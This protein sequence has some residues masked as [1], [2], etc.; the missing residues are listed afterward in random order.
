[1]AG[2]PSLERAGSVHAARLLLMLLLGV[3]LQNTGATRKKDMRTVSSVSLCGR[4]V[5]LGQEGISEGSEQA[6][7]SGGHSSLHA[8]N[9]LPARRMSAS[10]ELEC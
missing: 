7:C 2:E 10:G 9:Q 5:S 4:R 8:P 1:M 6:R 3:R